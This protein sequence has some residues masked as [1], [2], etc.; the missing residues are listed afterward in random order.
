MS[1][2]HPKLTHAAPDRG[3]ARWIIGTV[4]A[5]KRAFDRRALQHERRRECNLQHLVARQFD[6]VDACV[7]VT[8]FL[9]LQLKTWRADW[10]KLEVSVRPARKDL[11][12][13]RTPDHLDSRV[14]DDDA[15]ARPV[16]VDHASNRKQLTGVNRCDQYVCACVNRAIRRKDLGVTRSD[17]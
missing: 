2:G 15:F 1:D 7:V 12:V 9:E 16:L 17:N 5:L 11:S 8:L 6:D 4:R 3:G 10:G 13:E 14:I